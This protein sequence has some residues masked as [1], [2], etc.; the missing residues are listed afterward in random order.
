MHDA[1]L[2]SQRQALA[3]ARSL[4]DEE[5]R[6]AANAVDPEPDTD[7]DAEPAAPDPALAAARPRRFFGREAELAALR[8]ALATHRLV[9]LH[10]SAGCGKTALAAQALQRMRGFDITEFVWLEDLSATE[11]I[12]PQL[13]AALGL[14]KSDEEALAQVAAHLDGRPALLVLDNFEQ[15]AGPAG[16]AALD[17]LLQAL[18]SARFLVT[19]RRALHRADERCIEVL[20]F[21][22]PRLGDAIDAALRN[23]GVALFVAAAQGARADFTLNARN[24]E[25]V[26]EVCQILE[27]L[28]L[29]IELAAA[30]IRSHTPHEM[31]AGLA[32]SVKLIARVQLRGGMVGRHASLVG[33]AKSS[34]L[35]INR[36][37][38]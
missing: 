1:W 18:P 7:A 14:Q 5:A 15:L 32:R 10:G 25:G 16:D 19:T 2:H 30:K 22:L 34:C 29:A 38:A 33:P 23:P 13:R 24:L 28:P 4:A 9:T 26:I 17:R 31:G 37:T 3:G 6:A 36:M 27:G 11:R 12:A 21:P 35:T 20:P 8:Q